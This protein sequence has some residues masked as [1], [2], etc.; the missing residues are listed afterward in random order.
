[1]AKVSPYH[2]ATDENHYGQRNVYHNDNKC[3]D[4]NRILPENLMSGTGN[5]PLCDWCKTH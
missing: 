4:G 3:P 2:T 1:M 5:K